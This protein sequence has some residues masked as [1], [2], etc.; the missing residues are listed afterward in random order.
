MG[1]GIRVMAR[2]RFP[3]LRLPGPWLSVDA[4]HADCCAT[5][6]VRT[7]RVIQLNRQVHFHL[8]F[9]AGQSQISMRIAMASGSIN[10]IAISASTNFSP[11]G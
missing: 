2:P 8:A 1:L 4:M 3:E 7:T 5:A 10:A 6:A 11:Y 9:V